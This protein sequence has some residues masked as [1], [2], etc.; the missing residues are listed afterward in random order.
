[1]HE[2]LWHGRGGQG[3]F[4][5]AKL[6]AAAWVFADDGHSALAW[7]SFGPERRGAPVRA[8][9]RLAEGRC[10]DR[11]EI[12]KADI[13]V[14]LDA[15]LFDADKAREEL[16]AGGIILLN[17]SEA[18]PLPEAL[19]YDASKTAQAILGRNFP[20][21]ALFG[22]AAA[23]TGGISRTDLA[24]GI[25][26]CLKSAIAKANLEAAQAG[27]DALASREAA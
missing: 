26:A 5:A 25:S 22:A 9:T 16:K 7:P 18:S 13:S 24:A 3:A 12:R 1:M 14:Y 11:S 27:F 8:F 17:S 2:I 15:T 23:L 19:S 6:L 20:N 21:T 4:T 10:S